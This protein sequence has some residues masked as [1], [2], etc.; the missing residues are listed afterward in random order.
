MQMKTHFPDVDV[1]SFCRARFSSAA[2]FCFSTLLAGLWCKSHLQR[3]WSLTMSSHISMSMFITLMSLKQRHPS[4]ENRIVLA[5][6]CWWAVPHS[7]TLSESSH[8]AYGVRVQT[9]TVGER[10][11]V[12]VTGHV[13]GL[14]HW[15]PG[16]TK[17][18]TKCVLEKLKGAEASL[19]SEVDAPSL[20]AVEEHAD[21]VFSP[22]RGTEE[23]FMRDRQLHMQHVFPFHTTD[24]VQ[25]KG[26][27]QYSLAPQSSQEL[28][29]G[30]WTVYLTDLGY[31][32]K[33]A[34]V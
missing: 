33:A 30:S 18:C 10:C 22:A 20:A 6:S 31:G 7:V 17:W 13:W 21:D 25:G 4:S 15:W 3:E 19:L 32:R 34:A 24:I 29:E 26:R 12:C 5:P 14:R 2:S 28:P 16:R 11:I 8:L 27:C 1:F 9:I 23:S